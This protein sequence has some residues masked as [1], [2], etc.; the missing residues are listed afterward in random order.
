MGPGMTPPGAAGTRAAWMCRQVCRAI[1]L[2]VAV[3]AIDIGPKR[4]A[5]ILPENRAVGFVLGPERTL[6]GS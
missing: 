3:L 4:K 2:L 6:T 5:L 1:H